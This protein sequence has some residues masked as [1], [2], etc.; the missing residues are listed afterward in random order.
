MNLI[1]TSLRK[2]IGQFF[3]KIAEKAWPEQF[4]IEIANEFNS[5]LRNQ[6]DFLPKGKYVFGLADR[7][8]LV[9]KNRYRME[10]LPNQ[11]K[12]ASTEMGVGWVTEDNTAEGYDLL[13][14]D[15]SNLEAFRAE[16]NHV[17]D[18]LTVEIIDHICQYIPEDGSLLDI[19][20]GVGDLLQ[21]ARSRR[22]RI[23]LSGL[24]FSPKAIQGARSALPDGDFKEFVIE[25]HLPYESASFD[26]VLCTDVLEH[27][28]Y[29]QL[30][31]AE[32]V[33][34]CKPGG[35]VVIV[36][37]DGDVDTFLGHYWFWSQ[38]SFATFLAPWKPHVLRLPITKEF[39]AK[40][41]ILK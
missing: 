4:S 19:G 7:F 9:P 38:D 23:G 34:I 29:P 26:M 15:S 3:K 36:V 33:R 13:W 1:V 27:L 40:I 8:L 16:S 35:M 31:V 17:R 20:C 18:K 41:N 14:G 39:M 2:K 22:P 25:R 6:Y 30:V 21:E 28:L 32:L 10:L 11:E 24:D 5:A 37:P 12:Y